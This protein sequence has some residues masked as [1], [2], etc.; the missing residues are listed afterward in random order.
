MKVF[1]NDG[2]GAHHPRT[3]V[4]ALAQNQHPNSSHGRSGGRHEDST[5]SQIRSQLRGRR[6][7]YLSPRCIGADGFSDLANW[8]G[9]QLQYCEIADTGITGRIKDEI[10]RADC[11]LFTKSEIDRKSRDDLERFCRNNRRVLM[12]LRSA[13]RACFRNAILRLVD[14]SGLPRG[15]N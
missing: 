10:E 3:P 9:F 6:I 7:L 12:P 2:I 4:G 14:E 11:V 8:I 5:L 15:G 1:D 13:S